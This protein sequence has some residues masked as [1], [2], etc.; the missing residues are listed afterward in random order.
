MR[1]F[2]RGEMN[3]PESMRKILQILAITVVGIGASQAEAP[4]GEY[5]ELHSC[6]VYTGGCTASAQAQTGGRAMLR[7]WHFDG[8]SD[9]AGQTLAVLET[10]EENLAFKETQ[11]AARVAFLPASA[12]KEQGLAMAAWLEKGGVKPSET[13]T[14]PVSYQRSGSEIVV[15]AGQGI[16]FMTRAIEACDAGACGEQLWYVPRGKTASYTVLVNDHSSVEEPALRLSWKDHAAKS[17]FFGRFGEPGAAEFT[18][19][20]LP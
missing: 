20:S 16:S 7:V 8:K 19:A 17:V 2:L 4:R 11:P 18:L 1:S 12:S 6:E 9:W 15:K 3:Y 5:V 14:V 13:Q 10:A